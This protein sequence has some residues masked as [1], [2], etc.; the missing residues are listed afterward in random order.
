M[1]LPELLS[2]I[3]KNVKQPERIVVALS[4][5]S[6]DDGNRLHKKLQP[7]V[8]VSRLHILATPAQC[9]AGHNRNRGAKASREDILS[10]ID[11]DDLMAPERVQTVC[12]L[13]K[14]HRADAVVHSYRSKSPMLEKLAKPTWKYIASELS[15]EQFAQM[16]AADRRHTYLRVHFLAHG[17]ISVKTDAYWNVGGQRE[18]VR[19]GEDALF[20][21]DL[22]QRNFR[23]AYSPERLSYY[24]IWLSTRSEG[25]I[26]GHVLKYYWIYIL[27]LVSIVILT[28]TVVL[29]RR[30]RLS[31]KYL[32][33]AIS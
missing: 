25:K 24:R 28:I 32:P 14:R 29:V 26:L 13:L 22:C 9:L 16:E 23:V 11:A 2:S 20:I 33:R 19:S 5:T 21:R 10:F 7:I 15:P 12:N 1:Y 4:Q 3:A 27:I 18:H 30:R 8:P 31:S 17:H 6:H